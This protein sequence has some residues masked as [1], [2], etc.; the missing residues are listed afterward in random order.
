MEAMYI[1]RE[2]IMNMLSYVDFEKL[3]HVI[4][5]FPESPQ[6]FGKEDITF[7]LSSISRAIEWRKTF[8]IN[9]NQV[10]LKLIQEHTMNSQLIKIFLSRLYFY[11]RKG[12]E[13][14]MCS[15]IQ[16]EI[17]TAEENVHYLVFQVTYH[18]PF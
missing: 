1:A 12:N 15:I 11:K 5:Y 17:Y 6:K 10:C 14:Y 7:P 13:R 2:K 8:P 9:L 16:K 18:I 3:R 4:K